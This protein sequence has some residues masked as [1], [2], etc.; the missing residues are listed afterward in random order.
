MEKK[1]LGGA[2]GSSASKTDNQNPVTALRHSETDEVHRKLIQSAPDAVDRIKA[3]VLSPS[4]RVKKEIMVDL[5]KCIQYKF[6][7]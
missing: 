7:R 6:H 5:V 3:V 1:W 4:E 2:G